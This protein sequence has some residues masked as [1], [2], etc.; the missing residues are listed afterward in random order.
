M[1]SGWA[2]AG[3]SAL[4]G[5]GDGTAL[6]HVSAPPAPRPRFP[7]YLL[8]YAALGGV[9]AYLCATFVLPITAGA[10]PAVPAMLGPGG[11]CVS[12]L[13]WH[14]PA[15]SQHAD[16]AAQ[17]ASRIAAIRHLAVHFKRASHD[18]RAK[19]ATH[20]TPSPPP[21]LRSPPAGDMVRR[22]LAAGL[23]HTCEVLQRCLE[24]STGEVAPDTGLLAAVTGETHERI[25]L[26]SGLYASLQ[27]LYAAA[28]AGG[29]TIQV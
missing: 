26:D 28:T 29:R 3:A 13:G 18:A 25:G 4:L 24:I 23:Q 6:P 27:P 8:M 5:R 19:P 9:A 7:L 15:R 14:M 12:A 10:A 1:A 22:R 11:T 2:F 20:M 17:A 21:C 16:D